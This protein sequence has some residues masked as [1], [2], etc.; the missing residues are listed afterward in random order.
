M[1]AANDGFLKRTA[2]FFKDV[3]AEMKKVSWPDKNDLTTYT[4]VVLV[5]VLIVSGV[6]WIIDTG[7]YK[8]IT[9][10]LQ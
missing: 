9:L 10:I 7:L 4:L 6:I 2:K 8:L 5:S 3:R 1:A